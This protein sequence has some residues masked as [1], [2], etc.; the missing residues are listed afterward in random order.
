VCSNPSNY[1]F[2]DEIHPTAVGH[3][4]IAS[5]AAATLP[6]PE[7][8]FLSLIAIGAIGLLFARRGAD[9]AANS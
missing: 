7:P 8:P 3:S 4:I 5:A 6:V 1:L 2:W 9:T